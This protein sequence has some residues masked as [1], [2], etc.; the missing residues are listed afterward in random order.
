MAIYADDQA[1]LIVEDPEL[2]LFSG[3][4]F[5]RKDHPKIG[6]RGSLS[7]DFILEA[8]VDFRAALDAGGLEDRG[9]G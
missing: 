3:F 7:P 6:E 2:G 1:G 4:A 8:A 5:L 9:L